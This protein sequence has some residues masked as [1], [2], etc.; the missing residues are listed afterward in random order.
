MR[1]KKNYYDEMQKADRGRIGNQMFM[2][3]F[4]A[5]FL[6]QTLYSYGV[7]WLDYSVSILAISTVCMLVYLVRIVMAGAYLPAAFKGISGRATIV[8]LV[9][10]IVSAAFLLLRPDWFVGT[11]WETAAV[12]LAIGSL[13]FLI[14]NWA[15]AAVRKKID[16]K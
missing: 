14:K 6:N 16:S 2:I 9:L 7:I 5:I 10:L 3:L 11:A 1:D 8:V 13:V 15:A 12:M 4:F